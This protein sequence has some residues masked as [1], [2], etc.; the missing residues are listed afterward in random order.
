MPAIHQQHYTNLN[1]LLLQKRISKSY[2]FASVPP[3]NQA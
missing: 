2:K 1:A 3:S